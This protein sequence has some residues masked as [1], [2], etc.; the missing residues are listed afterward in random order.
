MLIGILSDIH[1][2]SFALESVLK[3]ARQAGVEKLFILGDLVGYFYYPEK[4]YQLLEDWDKYIIRGNHEDMFLDV[5]AGRLDAETVRKKYGSSLAHSIKVLPQEIKTEIG[6][7][8]RSATIIVDGLSIM[9]AHGAPWDTNQYIYPD[10][11]RETLSRCDMPGVDYV[12]VG[13]THYP[14]IFHGKSSILINPGSVGQSRAKGGVACWG[15]LNTE[16]GVY[17]QKYTQYDTREL[18]SICEA[19]DPDITYLTKILDRNN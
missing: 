15:V 9:L 14:F 19:A 5:I 18:K 17:I 6:G 12:F 8:E 16:N 3:E 7:Y 2:N 4:V 10:A 11:A 1:G 13:H